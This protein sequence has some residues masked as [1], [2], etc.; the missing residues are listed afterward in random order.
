MDARLLTSAKQVFLEL[1]GIAEVA[2]LTGSNYSAAANWSHE[3][4]F[5]ARTYITLQREL[6]RKECTAPDELWGMSPPVS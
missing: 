2:R 6:A 5:P 1:G 3:N 4:K